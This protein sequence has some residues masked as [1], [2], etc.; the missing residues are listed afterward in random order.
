M[1]S[2]TTIIHIYNLM[3]F[4]NRENDVEQRCQI[5]KFTRGKRNSLMQMLW[6][7]TTVINLLFLGVLQSIIC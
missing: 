4:N 5:K 7:F 1:L 3:I 2:L 6:R